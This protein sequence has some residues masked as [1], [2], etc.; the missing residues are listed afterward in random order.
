MRARA[1]TVVEDVL[2]GTAGLF[3]SVSQDGQPIPALLVVD[4]AGDAPRG[5]FVGVEPGLE[6]EGGAERIAR[7]AAHQGGQPRW[8]APGREGAA[9]GAGGLEG[10]PVEVAR[11]LD[12]GQQ[13]RP[14]Q[15]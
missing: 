4:A 8:R 15:L 3:E 14:L 6:E 2:V 7:Q 9:R 5:R 11:R 13:G 1:A 10:A 12:K